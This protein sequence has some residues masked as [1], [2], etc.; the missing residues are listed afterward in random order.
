MN[1]KKE[2]NLGEHVW[3]YN[4]ILKLDVCQKCGVR[5]AALFVHSGTH[6]AIKKGF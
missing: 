6:K 5:Q 3:R 1:E 2:C 4:Q